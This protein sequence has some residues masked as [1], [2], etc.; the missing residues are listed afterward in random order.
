M[1]I[2]KEVKTGILVLL[3]II[4]FIFGFSYLKGKNLLESTN[5]YYTEFNYNALSKSS[6]VTVKGN[7]VGKITDIIYDYK[8]GKTRVAFFVNEQLKFSKNSIVRM[9]ETGLMGGNGLAIIVSDE[10]EMAKPGDILQSEVEVGLVTSLSKNFS[11][12][13]TDLNSTLKSTD[14]LMSSLN[15]LVTDES[16]KGL[17]ATIKELNETLKSFKNTS[18][19]VNGLIAQNDDKIAEIL[20]KFKTTSNDLALMTDELK[21]ANIGNTVETLKT[22]LTNLN[23]LLEKVNNGEGSIGKL[24]KDEGL[25]NNLE[26]ATLQLEQLLE[27]MKLNPKRYVH[28]SLFGKKAK[29]YDAEGNEIKN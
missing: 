26:G 23:G 13:S 14:T 2:S 21:D 1:K 7:S 6:L 5:I 18:N 22:T 8:T 25:Y 27:D 16:S 29:Q 11:G 9:Y 28:F 20:E 12:L 24:L 4:L 10:G 19:S 3:G 15:K 17:K